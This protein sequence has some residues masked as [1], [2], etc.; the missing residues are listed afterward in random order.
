MLKALIDPNVAP[1]RTLPREERELMIAANNGYALAFD[2]LSGLPA[3]L[4]PRLE[5]IELQGDRVS[6]ERASRGFVVS[7]TQP[8]AKAFAAD[9]PGFPMTIDQEIGKGGAGGPNPRLSSAEAILP[10]S[11]SS[12]SRRADDC[13]AS[14]IVG[15][16][17]PAIPA[18]WPLPG[19][20]D[21]TRD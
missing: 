12:L 18:S 14:I 17:P 11:A 4:R 3:W 5:Q 9:G 16:L 1:V 19:L 20:R 21:G 6:G 8:A 7:A 15:A 10:M 2:N 13:S